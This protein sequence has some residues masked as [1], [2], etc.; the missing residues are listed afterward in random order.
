MSALSDAFFTPVNEEDKAK[1]QERHA[2][3]RAVDNARGLTQ[4]ELDAKPDRYWRRHCRVATR[5]AED[6]MARL[7][8]VMEE[9]SKPDGPGFDLTLGSIVTTVA[10]SHVHQNVLKLVEGGHVCGESLACCTWCPKHH[11][12][13]S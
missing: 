6:M 2:E 7:D 8:A 11:D 4:Q 3:L 12:I 5:S 13:R 9:F 10:T 1:V